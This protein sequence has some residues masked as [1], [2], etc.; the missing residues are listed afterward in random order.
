M[1]L[2][3]NDG[4]L[5]RN[6][7]KRFILAVYDYA[8][9]RIN[10]VN[11]SSC[12]KFTELKIGHPSHY[13]T[14]E[15]ML[16]HIEI[17][18]NAMETI[19]RKH[20]YGD[21]QEEQVKGFIIHVVLH[22]L[23]HMDQAVEFG[24]DNKTKKEY[25]K[26]MENAND[27]YTFNWIIKHKEELVKRFGHFLLDLAYTVSAYAYDN[28]FTYKR[29]SSVSEVLKSLLY[30]LSNVDIE[31]LIQTFNSVFILMILKL[32]NGAHFR[33]LILG[34]YDDSPVKIRKIRD[35]LTFLDQNVIQKNRV[36]T[37]KAWLEY[38][39]H[40]VLKPDNKPNSRVFSIPFLVITLEET[41]EETKTFTIEY[42]KEKA[43]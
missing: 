32:R 26:R 13:L 27:T 28:R 33:C 38:D 5:H 16:D 3:N 43:R 2:I 7:A 14:G 40:I 8:N 9:G 15:R 39:E 12:L 31:K 25:Q 24:Q 35:L 20:H 37:S 42:K 11:R 17:N 41:T 19:V 29:I 21:E 34:K 1:N 23:A 36:F 30:F 10:S 18:L 6:N 22:E 4:F